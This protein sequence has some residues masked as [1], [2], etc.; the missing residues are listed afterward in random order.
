[1]VLH[2]G[3]SLKPM[4]RPSLS[5]GSKISQEAAI[6]HGCAEIRGTEKVN[7]HFRH[8][9]LALRPLKF[10]RYNPD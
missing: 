7:N 1:M 10:H 3:R 6:H 4:E 5:S 9:A 2:L 8:S